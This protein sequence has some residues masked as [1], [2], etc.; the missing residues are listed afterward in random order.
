MRHPEAPVDGLLIIHI[1]PEVM[2]FWPRVFPRFPGRTYRY[3]YGSMFGRGLDRDDVPVFFPIEFILFWLGCT[4]TDAV[5][6]KTMRKW[7]NEAKREQ[8]GEKGL[9]LT[10]VERNVPYGTD[11][12]MRDVLEHAHLTKLAGD[13]WYTPM[14]SAR[15]LEAAKK[16]A[17]IRC[18]G[19][20][21]TTLTHEMAM[22]M[23]E[24]CNQ[25]E[26]AATGQWRIPRLMHLTKVGRPVHAH[27]DVAMRTAHKVKPCPAQHTHTHTPHH[28]H[29]HHHHHHRS[30]PDRQWTV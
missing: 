20:R 7:A 26:M 18:G 21:C 16:R 5:S 13:V 1:N 4:T 3:S 15:A 19:T 23:R 17:R 29:H 28:H 6:V 11:R 27:R 2:V 25:T 30:N 14:H 10:T 22:V 9:P 24:E 12:I 8:A